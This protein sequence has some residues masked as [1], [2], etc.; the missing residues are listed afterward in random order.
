MKTLVPSRTAAARRVALA[1]ANVRVPRAEV[2]SDDELLALGADTD[3][4]VKYE[5][6]DGRVVAMPPARPRHGAIIMRLAVAVGA[7]VYAH[8]LGELFD[9]QTGF[10]LSVDH[11]FEP[12]IAFVSHARMK[13]IHPH[14][15]KLFHGAPDL[16]IEVL[17]PSD[18]ITKTERKLALYLAHGAALAWMVDPKSK[19]IRVYRKSGEFELLSQDRILTGNS[20]LPGFRL[21]LHRLFDEL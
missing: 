3:I 12:D 19:T 16:A 21:S 13:L 15:E 5:L 9:G 8:E 11:C 20:V 17:S 2:W 10:R 4:K 6:W 14:K 1:P 18:S 7:Y